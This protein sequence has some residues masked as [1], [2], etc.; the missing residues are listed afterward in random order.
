MR[1]EVLLF[2]PEGLCARRGLLADGVPCA[3][4]ALYS[5]KPRAVTVSNEQKE[6][7]S[8]RDWP[9]AFRHRSESRGISLCAFKGVQW[10]CSTVVPNQKIAPS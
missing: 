2:K 3:I 6:L 1:T 9:F 8:E 4:K 10:S 5:A 7:V